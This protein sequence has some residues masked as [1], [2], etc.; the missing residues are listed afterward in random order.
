[1]GAPTS[2]RRTTKR[3]DFTFEN[4][5]GTGPYGIY[6]SKI[7]SSMT[8]FNDCQRLDTADGRCLSYYR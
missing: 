7:R 2:T 8:I 4:D 6:V 3:F 1:M 5:T